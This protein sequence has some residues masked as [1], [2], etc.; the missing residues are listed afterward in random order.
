MATHTMNSDIQRREKRMTT[1]DEARA[2]QAQRNQTTFTI[3]D[4]PTGCN[5][6]P[7]PTEDSPFSW[8]MKSKSRWDMTLEVEDLEEEVDHGLTEEYLVGCS[9]VY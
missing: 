3:R 6:Q 1:K 2:R 4:I 8:D 5:P 9:S 7:I